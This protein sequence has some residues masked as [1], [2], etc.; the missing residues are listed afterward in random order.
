MAHHEHF[1]CTAIIIPDYYGLPRT[2]LVLLA[3][4]W[5]L[6]AGMLYSAPVRGYVVTCERTS[7][8]S[9]VLEQTGASGMRRTTVPLP[10]GAAAVVRILPRTGGAGT[11]ADL[12]RAAVRLPDR[13]VVRPWRDGTDDPVGIP[14]VAPSRPMSSRTLATTART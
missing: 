14:G 13:R 1:R 4:L 12:G 7:D 8:L 10:N 5:V 6:G 3:A 2:I 11:R 9:C